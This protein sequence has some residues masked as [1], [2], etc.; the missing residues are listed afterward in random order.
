MSLDC[1]GFLPGFRSCSLLVSLDAG[2]GN[3]IFLA[4]L[5]GPENGGMNKWHQRVI[6]FCYDF[7]IILEALFQSSARIYNYIDLTQLF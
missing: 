5:R 7:S 3:L 2:L 6:S 4:K 1:S